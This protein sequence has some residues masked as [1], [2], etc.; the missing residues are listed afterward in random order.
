MVEKAKAIASETT[1]QSRVFATNLW[2]LLVAVS[3]LVVA[4]YVIY[5]V[6]RQIDGLDALMVVGFA[7]SVVAISGTGALVRFLMNKGV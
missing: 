2:N 7:A 4:G 5:V 3:M 6:R 1:H